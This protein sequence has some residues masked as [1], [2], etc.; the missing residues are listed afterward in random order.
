MIDARWVCGLEFGDGGRL[1]DVVGSS[2]VGVG[3]DG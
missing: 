1:G 2:V 3:S